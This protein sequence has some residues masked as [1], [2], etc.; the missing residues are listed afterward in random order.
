MNFKTK[1]D[2]YFADN[3]STQ[4]VLGKK[5]RFPTLR[6]LYSG[7]L[8]RFI[9]N[10]N[11]KSEA[12]YNIE[13]NW[14]Y[15]LNNNKFNLSFFYSLLNNG[16]QRITLPGKQFKRINKNQIRTWGIEFSSKIN[17]IKKINLDFNFS[18]LHSFSKN[19]KDEFQDTLEYK[20]QIISGFLLNYIVANNLNLDMEL[21]YIGKEFGLQEGSKFYQKL[22]DYFLLNLRI[23]YNY[24]ISKNV[25]VETFLR[26]NNLLD[27]LYF[28]Q[29]SLPEPGR[30]FLFGLKLN[31]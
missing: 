4:L 17:F 7:A 30:Q 9:P 19:N 25:N 3:I 13:S 6:E 14:K 1:S 20:P 31:Y 15:L 21:N 10:P 2:Y 8:G 11:L 26:V 28:T 12:A 18:Y 24:K 27:K 16:I 29:W 5:T 22:P 23:S